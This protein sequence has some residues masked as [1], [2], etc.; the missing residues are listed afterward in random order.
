MC[1][2]LA[3]AQ[4]VQ[5]G[6]VSYW[7]FDNVAGKTVQ[8]DWSENH[9]TIKG[10]PRKVAGKYGSALKFDGEKDQ[11]VVP[12]DGSLNIVDNITLCAWIFWNGQTGIIASKR[13]P[14][15]FQFSAIQAG[16]PNTIQ[17]CAPSCIYSDAVLSANEWMYIAA[18]RSG[19]K[20]HF[21]KDGKTAGVF[22]QPDAWVENSVDLYIG[23]WPG[24]GF[25][26]GGIL[27]ELCIYNRALNAG[28]IKQNFTSKGLAVVSSPEK[29]TLTWGKMKISK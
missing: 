28:E 25:K 19:D 29:L 3:K 15:S 1:A 8:D 17:L 11:I 7:S 9:G 14:L 22:D 18:A 5:K 13:D 4:V 6:L 26:Y 23:A 2:N 20:I 16:H 24:E 27:D 21:Y 10:A 12:N